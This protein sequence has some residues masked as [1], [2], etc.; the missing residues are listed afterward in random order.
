MPNGLLAGHNSHWRIMGVGSRPALMIH[1]SLA[2]SKSWGPLAAR[3]GDAMTMTAFDLPG[4]GRSD[5]WDGVTEIQGQCVAMARALLPDVPVDL[6][7]HSFG[8]TVALRLALEEPHRVNTLTLIEPV[9]FAAATAEN[10]ETSDRVSTLFSGFEAAWADGDRE[11]AARQFMAVWGD[12]TPWDTFPE[13]Q[14]LALADQIHLIPASHGALHEDAGRILNGKKLEA[15]DVPVLLIEG[16]DTNW[17][18]SSIHDVLEARLAHVRR[19][20]IAGA[21]HM[22]P[23]T[24]PDEVA[25]AI[26]AFL[27]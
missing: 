10:Q 13:R 9:L 7:G 15:L 12:G 1:C 26:R 27:P 22:T 6:V 11:A 5:P 4:H 17:V 2:S 3:L 21:G 14:R 25:E 8:A 19:V 18:I 23:M 16:A 20:S 24:H